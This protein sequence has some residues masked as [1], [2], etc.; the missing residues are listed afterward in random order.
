VAGEVLTVGREVAAHRRH[1][2]VVVARVHDG[3]PE[4]EQRG[5]PRRLLR[6]R[7]RCDDRRGS[8]AEDPMQNEYRRRHD[9]ES[10]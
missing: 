4:H 10:A 9:K 7:R 8:S 5:C 3:V 6:R 2:G 1:D